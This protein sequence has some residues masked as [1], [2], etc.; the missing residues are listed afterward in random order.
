MTIERRA[1]LALLAGLA[2]A[3]WSAQADTWPARPV[4]IL[5]PAP[6]GGTSDIVARAVAEAMRRNT[7]QAIVVD[8]KPGAAGAIAADAFLTAPRDGYTLLFAPSSLVTEVPYTIRPRYDPFQD[9]VPVA[10][11]AS[12][13]MV[14]VANANL[15][16]QNL[17]EM[18][19]WVK[20]RPG[21]TS[22]ASYSPGT[23]SHVKGLQF[24]K[25]A[26]IDMQHVAYKGS[27]PA[28]QDVVGG[29]VEFMVDG[30]AT[31]AP[32]VKAGKLKAL[33]VS[34]P[35]RS[36][37][38]PDVPTFAELGYPELTQ[39]IAMD[40]FATPQV[41]AGVFARVR[42]ELL[43]ALASPELLATFRANGLQVGPA[44]QTTEELR[45]VLRRD[46]E[47]TGESLRAIDYKPQQ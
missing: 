36:S 42:A 24:N 39:T 17:K 32:H 27:P 6:A 43:K 8:N 40:I 29:Q 7:G 15:P 47:R 1:C 13:G 3:P 19:A 26:G 41:P 20:A 16:I 25:A 10:E 2:A 12:I 46:Y 4:K 11:L 18:V 34:S 30:I 37:A 28:L 33:A 45:Q 44:A 14:L 5:V 23:I 21:K 38:L 22:F 31:S 9:L 35:Q